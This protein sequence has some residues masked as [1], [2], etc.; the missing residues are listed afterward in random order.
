L[1]VQRG[2]DEVLIPVYDMI[3]HRNGPHY[4]YN[5]REVHSVHTPNQ[6]VQVKATRDI[7][8]GQELYT[9]YSSCLDCG[10]RSS[11]YGTPEILRDYGFVEVYPQRWDFPSQDVAFSLDYEYNSATG[12]PIMT[13]EN[14]D[15][16]VVLIWHEKPSVIPVEF[17]AQQLVRLGEFAS[18]ELNA[19]KPQD[20]PQHEFD[21]LNRYHG[22]LQNAMQKL[23]KAV[24]DGVDED[25]E[26][27]D[28]EEAMKMDFLPPNVDHGERQVAWVRE[29]RGFVTEKM[30]IRKLENVDDSHSYGVFATQDIEESE[31]M[32]S[33]PRPCVFQTF[34]D[35]KCDTVDK[36]AQEMRKGEESFWEP[37][38]SY[39]KSQPYGQLPSLWSEAGK[40]ALS[41][42]NWEYDE[43]DDEWYLVLPPEGMEDARFIGC[44]NLA[45]DADTPLIDKLAAMLVTQRGWDEVL[46]PVYDL[47]SHRNGEGYLNT[48]EVHSVHD[49][50]LPVK[51]QASRKIKAGEE[52]YTSY[53]SCFDCGARARGYGSP[54]I[55]RDYGFVEMLPQKFTVGPNEAHRISFTLDSRKTKD[56][57]DELF[58]T[59]EDGK[60]PG[61]GI[62]NFMERQSDRLRALGGGMFAPDADKPHNVPQHEWDTILR[63]HK[64]MLTALDEA[65]NAAGQEDLC[66]ENPTSNECKVTDERYS[67]LD[68]MFDDEDYNRYVC[69][70]NWEFPGYKQLEVV[71][72]AYQNIR[73]IQDPKNLDTCFSLDDTWQQCGSYRPHYHEMTTAYAARFIPEIKRVLWVGG[74][75]SFL[76]HE[77]L[78]YPSL[79]FVVGLELDQQVTRSAFKHF[80]SQPHWDNPKVQWWYGDGAKSLLM[81]PK[82]YFGTFDLVLADMS[83]TIMSNLVTNGLDIM[84]AMTLLLKPDGIMVKNE[85]YLEK[86]NKI[87][88]NTIQLHF[89]DVP[90]LCSQALI[91]GSDAID[92]LN[93]DLTDHGIDDQNLFITP[94]KDYDYRYHE[95]HDY[96]KNPYPQKACKNE[97]DVV[98]DVVDSNFQERSPGVVMVLEAEKADAKIL[99]SEKSLKDA[100]VPALQKQ[101]LSIVT[102]IGSTNDDGL[103]TL[104]VMMEEGY[105]VARAWPGASYVAYDLHLWSVFPKIQEIKTALLEAVK[106]QSSSVFRIVAGGMFGVDTWK[107]DEKS[108]GPDF[109]TCEGTDSAP[110]RAVP[111]AESITDTILEESI[112]LLTETD[113]VAAI[114]CGDSENAC[115]NSIKILKKHKSVKKVIPLTCDNIASVSDEEDA[116]QEKFLCESSVFSALQGAG[117]KIGMLVLDAKAPVA[118]GQVMNKVTSRIKNK[119]TLFSDQMLVLAPMVNEA[120]EW[121]RVFVD[122]FREVYR[123]DPVFRSQVL[124]NTTDSSMEMGSFLPGDAHFIERLKAVN[125]KIE[126][127]NA[128]AGL[129][130]DLRTI[131]GAIFPLV[132]DPQPTVFSLPGDYDQRGPYEQWKSQQ[133]TGFQTIVQFEVAAKGTSMTA[134][135]LKSLLS[136]TLSTLKIETTEPVQEFTDMGDGSVVAA[137]WADGGVVALWD[138]RTHVGVNLFTYQEDLDF[139]QKFRDLFPRTSSLSVALR[140]EMPR[141][142]GRVVSFAKD[143]SDTRNSD[144]TTTREDP[145]WAAS[146]IS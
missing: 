51:V 97:T 15:D 72:S 48:R 31:L 1:V 94:L 111:I 65:V 50:D 21:T 27:I 16:N 10:G 70:I 43:E 90:V 74:G 57:E 127:R 93:V 140:D 125:E 60:F 91:F 131:E 73:F 117:E 34:Q 25:E 22:A 46:I 119:N 38:V 58:V 144:P 113:V 77:I 3:S 110:V 80:G 86:L 32:L 11:G 137:L 87:F 146:V 129:L 40:E 89:Y 41:F 84:A 35:D 53:D 7:A 88:K 79:E 103:P 92:F 130:S 141:G 33:I 120:E 142:H 98:D 104:V 8:K 63:Y 123:V 99:K 69:D 64:T 108:R 102:T 145:H 56:G 85:I 6:P 44:R 2:W 75:D 138:G 139:A 109:E 143:L 100:I 23:I 17:F 66:L 30:E 81:L 18:K 83:E 42:V 28:D 9:S 36:L 95:I 49:R 126:A 13:S 4:W 78:K 45:P 71:K 26:D 107:V 122:R 112:E 115:K 76:L 96:V 105:V 20:M 116:A 39:L 67:D 52:V 68:E 114:A 61:D 124:F 106:S 5:T 37:Y 136:R 24:E 132:E 29:N 133:P 59:W 134:A 118:M 121:R 54:E 82:E 19:G 14:D 128:A 62:V 101:D 135:S 55:F 12:E 47:M